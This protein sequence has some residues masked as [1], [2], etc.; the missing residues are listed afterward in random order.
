MIFLERYQHVVNVITHAKANKNPVADPYRSRAIKV[1]NV[2]TD[3]T[4]MA[5]YVASES[6][7]AKFK[8]IC[9]VQTFLK[10]FHMEI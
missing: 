8:I 4:I 9:S 6:L 5:R 1:L 10:I 7:M 3:V 2:R